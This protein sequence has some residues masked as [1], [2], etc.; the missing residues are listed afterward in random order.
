MDNVQTKYWFDLASQHI[1]CPNMRTFKSLFGV[2]PKVCSFIFL[3]YNIHIISPLHL[4]W[5]LNFLKDYSVIYS[6]AA[7]WNVS[8]F[9]FGNAVWDL[10]G[11][12]NDAMSGVVC[13]LKLFKKKN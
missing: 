7:M 3:N 11:N 12:L 6:L 5:T 8:T 10:I 4:L 2:E 13:S 9:T 1:H